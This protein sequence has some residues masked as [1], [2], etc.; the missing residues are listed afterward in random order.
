MEV[1]EAA[2]WVARWEEGSLLEEKRKERE[3]NG[4][5]VFFILQVLQ[6]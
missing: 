5:S 2:G 6:K 3:Y 4:K 1:E